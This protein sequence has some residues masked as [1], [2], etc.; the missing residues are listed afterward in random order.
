[1][2]D[3]DAAGESEGFAAA[4][5]IQDGEA[6]SLGLALQD[7]GDEAG[8]VVDMDEL[9]LVIEIVLA[10]GQHAGKTLAFL[11]HAL[12]SL[13]FAVG[14]APGRADQIILNAG[15]GKDVGAENVGAAAAE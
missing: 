11:A 3:F 9:D 4:G 1:M 13:P 10:I 14:R 8:H 7:P 15:S 5:D 2:R 6:A 12:G